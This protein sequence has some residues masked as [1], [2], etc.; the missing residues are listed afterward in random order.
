[1]RLTTRGQAALTAMADIATH[2]S[3]DPVSLREISTRQNISVSYLEQLV[4]KMRY[5]GLLKSLRGR[6]GGYR[7][8]R[9]AGRITVAEIILCVDET[10]YAKQN[11]RSKNGHGRE[12]FLF[13]HLWSSLNTIALD[14]LSTLTL[15]QAI[16]VQAFR[17]A[18]AS[19][20]SSA[21]K[22]MPRRDIASLPLGVE[23][24]LSAPKTATAGRLEGLRLQRGFALADSSIALAALGIL[25][26]FA[27]LAC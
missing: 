26:A 5:R 9:S 24:R 12:Q 10:V 25:A 1:M 2:E 19:P 17:Q 6:H 16:E 11:V 22:A 23:P 8:S 13:Q 15:Q 3:V 21:R 7:L 18:H 27:L 14:Y 4:S 20:P